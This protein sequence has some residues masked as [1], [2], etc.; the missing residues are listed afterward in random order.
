MNQPLPLTFSI[1]FIVAQAG[2][3]EFTDE[4]YSQAWV[5]VV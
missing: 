4:P 5:Q 3:G 2:G 1:T